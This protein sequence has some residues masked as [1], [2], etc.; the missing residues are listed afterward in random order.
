MYTD[1]KLDIRGPERPRRTFHVR[2]DLSLACSRVAVRVHA[3]QI[4]IQ[5]YQVFLGDANQAALALAFTLH[6]VAS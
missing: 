3:T 1:H 5:I 4:I 2:P 6:L